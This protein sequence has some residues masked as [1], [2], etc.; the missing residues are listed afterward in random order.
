MGEDK[1]ESEATVTTVFTPID[2]VFTTDT[3]VGFDAAAFTLATAV[4]SFVVS[5]D[6][7]FSPSTPFESSRSCSLFFFTIAFRFSLFLHSLT[8]LLFFKS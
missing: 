4:F 3:D 1:G 7:A 8:S 2:W 6:A 5:L